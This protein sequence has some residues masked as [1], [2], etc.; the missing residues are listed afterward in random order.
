MQ[1]RIDDFH[2]KNWKSYFLKQQFMLRSFFKKKNSMWLTD[3]IFEREN[4]NMTPARDLLL[5][6]NCFIN[7]ENVIQMEE[8][9]IDRNEKCNIRYTCIFVNIL[10][11]YDLFASTINSCFQRTGRKL[12]M[13]LHIGYW[14]FRFK[15]S[16]Q[17]MLK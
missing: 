8:F 7:L 12:Y 13:T 1:F 3:F 10:H 14:D 9:K 6:R 11:T 2:Q 16:L 4:F 5:K 15:I 17:V